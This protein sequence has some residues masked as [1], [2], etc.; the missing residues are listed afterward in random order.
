MPRSFQK[1]RGKPRLELQ[2]ENAQL[3]QQSQQP[4]KSRLSK[5][6]LKNDKDKNNKDDEDKTAQNEQE[7]QEKM[8]KHV[9]VSKSNP[10]AAPLQRSEFAVRFP[11]SRETYIRTIFAKVSCVF[12]LQPL[13]SSC[14]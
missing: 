4:T 12:L 7:T 6:K 5:I 9:S 13:Y 10:I 3:P 2:Q 11:H 8:W 14:S 1:R